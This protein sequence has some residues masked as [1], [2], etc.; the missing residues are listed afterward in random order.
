MVSQK[1]VEFVARVD[2]LLINFLRKLIIH[3]E[4]GEMHRKYKKMKNQRKNKESN[5]NTVIQITF[6][7]QQG[8]R[9]EVQPEN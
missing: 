4:D 8:V 1:H 3:E 6:E 5:L 9:R 2:I 7:E